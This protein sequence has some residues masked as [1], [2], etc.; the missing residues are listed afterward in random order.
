M[1]KIRILAFVQARLIKRLPNKVL[2]KID[3][4]ASYRKYIF[5]VKKFKIFK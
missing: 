1:K 3:D 4:K 5:K 2:L